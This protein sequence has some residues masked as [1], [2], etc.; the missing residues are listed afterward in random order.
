MVL[1]ASF[2]GRS[3]NP[4]WYLNLQSDPAVRVQIRDELLDLTARDA[5]AAER[6]PY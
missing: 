3:R 5:T 4:A 1:P 2:G 6:D